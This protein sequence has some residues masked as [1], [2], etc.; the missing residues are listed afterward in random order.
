MQFL[1]LMQHHTLDVG[2]IWITHFR[3]SLMISCS[4]NILLCVHIFSSVSRDQILSHSLY[5][6]IEE[7]AFISCLILFLHD[8]NLALTFI[9][10]FFMQWLTR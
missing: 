2:K 3:L 1:S 4:V 5:M 8:S 10:L 7:V 6:D 9:G